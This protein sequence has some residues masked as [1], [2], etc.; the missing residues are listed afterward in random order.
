MAGEKKKKIERESRKNNGV[1]H[2]FSRI[3]LTICWLN[4]SFHRL[5]KM[6]KRINYRRMLHSREMLRVTSREKQ[7]KIFKKEESH[8]FVWRY[9]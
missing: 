1:E 5:R 8:Q 9:R 6:G 3:N 4:S 7:P 2:P